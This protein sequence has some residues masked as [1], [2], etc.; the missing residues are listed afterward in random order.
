MDSFV[1]L[2]ALGGWEHDVHFTGGE[3][4]VEYY[5]KVHNRALLW[6]CWPQSRLFL[7]DSGDAFL[8]QEGRVVF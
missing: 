7:M 2:T 5:V 6:H 1:P 3:M 4:E 8:E